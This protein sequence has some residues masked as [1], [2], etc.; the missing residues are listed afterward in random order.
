MWRDVT[1][2]LGDYI[3]RKDGTE[4]RIELFT[5][6]VIDF[7]TLENKD[8]GRGRKYYRVVIDEAAKVSGL[9]GIWTAAIRP[10]LTDY[11]GDAWFLSTP[12]GRNDF[13]R[14]FAMGQ[15]PLLT[16]WSCWQ[17]PTVDNPF[18]DPAEIEAA[19][20]DLPEDIFRQEYL[21]EFLEDGTVF[22]NL[23]QAATAEEQRYKD[24][25]LGHRY[26]MGVDLARLEDFTVITVIDTDR[27]EHCFTER[28]NQI[29]WPVQ[30]R[31]IKDIAKRFDVDSM[32]VDQTGVGDVIV[33]QLQEELGLTVTGITLNNDNKAELIDTLKLAFEKGTLKILDDQVLMNELMA[34]EAT[35]T[36]G[37]RIRYAAPAGYHDDCVM[38]LALALHASKSYYRPVT[39]SY[40]KMVR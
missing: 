29:D 23:T 6:G 13:W 15:D 9:W 14:L 31:R 30:V 37:G 7:W 2:E 27:N 5:G 11:K 3:T 39:V 38:S 25:N 24:Y 21:A 20:K 34:F 12:K 26:V 8:A 19:R 16:E 28:F 22:S 33:Q 18:I 35:R 17:L 1:N 4:H 10:T 32:V 36:P 40:R